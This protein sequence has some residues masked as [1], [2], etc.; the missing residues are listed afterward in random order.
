MEYEQI[1][2][3]IEDFGDSNLSTINIEFPNGLKVNMQKD[4]NT[5]KKIENDKILKNEEKKEIIEKKDIPEKSNII[6]SPMVGIF[7]SKPS[8]N[9]KNYVE[10]NMEVKK[11]DTLCIIEAMKLMNEI[12]SEYSGKIKKIYV[13]DGSPV[14]YGT[15]LFEIE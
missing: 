10:E 11:G 13:K 7:Y 9:E 1:K 12:E 14:E 2:K 3:I 8:P 4:N 6:K 5:S 15:P